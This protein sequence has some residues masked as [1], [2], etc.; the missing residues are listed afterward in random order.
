[1]LV[2]PI[3]GTSRY[4]QGESMFCHTV[5]LMQGRQMLASLIYS[6]LFKRLYTAVAGTGT[7]VTAFGSTP[8]LI[9]LAPSQGRTFLH[10]VRRIPSGVLKGLRT[11]GYSPVESSQ[12][13]SD[14][15]AMLTNDVAGFISV[16]PGVYDVWSPAM[17]VQ[18]AGGWL[19]DWQGNSLEF[20]GELRVPEV[21]VT[22]SEEDLCVVLPVLASARTERGASETSLE[23][24]Q[25][26]Q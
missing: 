1:M 9:R 2:D 7:W 15:I 8:K 21:L 4:C 14:L 20:S 16:K 10:H 6:H 23:T 24:T 19:S 22:R 26:P 5:S 18:E 12:N 3:D 11:K 25:N 17:L 13:A